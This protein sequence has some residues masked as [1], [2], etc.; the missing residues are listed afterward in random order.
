ML[1]ALACDSGVCTLQSLFPSKMVI[2][3]NETIGI[4]ARDA[5][6]NIFLMKKI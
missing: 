5:Q 2:P 3:A 1:V 6:G 4:G